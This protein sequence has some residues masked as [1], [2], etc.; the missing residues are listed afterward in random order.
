[1]EFLR[2]AYR[3]TARRLKMKQWLILALRML[4]FAALAL[5]LARP[6][7]IPTVSNL[8]GSEEANTAINGPH[9]IILDLSYPMGYTVN[10]IDNKTLFDVARSHALRVLS[11]SG[12][13]TAL[14]TLGKK[15]R[16]VSG[17]LTADHPL[18]Q[19]SLRHLKVGEHLAELNEAFSLAY[20][21]LRDRPK[22]EPKHITLLSIPNRSISELAPA[23]PALGQVN[24]I[25][26]DLRQNQ[27]N[28]TQE[29]E[30]INADRP[31]LSK[32]ARAQLDNHAITS[33]TLSPAPHMGSNQWRIE[34]EV[35]NYSSEAMNLW[36][37]WVEVEGEVL[38]RGFLSLAPNEIGIKRLYFQVDQKQHDPSQET[39]GEQTDHSQATHPPLLPLAKKGWV[40]LAPDALSIDDEWPFWIEA[41]PPTSILALNGDPR[42]TPHDDEL[43]Y[44]ERALSPQVLG[45]TKVK[46][47][48]R[49]MIGSEVKD[50]YLE[51]MDLILLANVPRPTPK[52]GQQL[53]SHLNAG[54]GLWLAP[55]AR[56]DV[57]AWNQ[58]LREILPRPLRGIRRAGDAAAVE[59]RGV[60][61]LSDFTEHSLL[62]P[63][64]DP[65]R[66]SLALAGIQRYFLFDPLPIPQ[67]ETVVTLNEGSPFMMT[68]QVGEGRVLL[69]AGPID[70]EWSDLVIY[71]DFVP[72][73]AETIRYL[74]KEVASGT[75]GTSLSQSLSLELN[76]D[77]PFFALSPKG[78]RLSLS[79]HRNSSSSSVKRGWKANLFK[80]RGHYKVVTPTSALQNSQKINLHNSEHTLRHFVV[81]LDTR[82][83]DLRGQVTKNIDQSDTNATSLFSALEQ[84]HELWHLGLIGLFIFTLLEGLALF[85]R[86]ESKPA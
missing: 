60:A 1:M 23:P 70:R 69:W 54:G 25:Q 76:G 57:E 75:L 22:N 28:E 72:L 80:H 31:Q 49:P 7:W 63:F 73:A 30:D 86:R 64:E 5:A 39:L 15:T 12:D 18:L 6:L 21:M 62:K 78:E 34:V 48:S 17:S 32:K 85:Q 81:H 40:K 46:L 9:V 11:D 36:P 29:K 50:E 84:R 74:T 71:P 10:E 45:D 52:L 65:N 77:G 26:V 61:R 38:V 37:I 58:A 16:S 67:T 2:R 47:Y 43:F 51:G 8:S 83:S 4:L 79:R 82:D 66:S 24:I 68:R 41:K 55:G 19:E 35:A 20:Q 3:K 42:P 13:P 56:S 27:T 33:L 14:I 53:K 44:L 59:R